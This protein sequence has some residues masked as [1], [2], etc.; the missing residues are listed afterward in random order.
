MTTPE[1]RKRQAPIR[2]IFT[3]RAL[4]SLKAGDRRISVFD[5]RA[6]GLGVCVQ[7][8]G[9]KSYFHL[10]SVQGRPVRKVLGKVGEIALEDA[11]HKAAEL[12][13][14]LGKWKFDEYETP[15]PLLVSDELRIAGLMRLYL[16]RRI[17][18]HSVRPDD[19]RKRILWMATRYFPSLQ[20]RLIGSITRMDLMELHGQIA[21]DSGP[22]IAN[23]VIELVRTLYSWAT[24]A[25]LWLGRNPA[26]KFEMLEENERERF[27]QPSEMPKFFQALGK[28]SPDF[29]D[30]IRLSLFTG[31][32]KHDI[33]SMSWDDVNIDDEQWIV[34]HPK[35]EMPYVVAL[36][37]ETIEILEAR[38]LRAIPG[39][40]W[41]FPSTSKD[42]HVLDMKT[43]WR[44]F[45][46][47]TGLRDLHPHDLRRSLG[48]W[49]AGLNASMP[50]IAKALGHRSIDATKVYSRVNLDPVRKSIQAAARAMIAAG[51]KKPKQL[52][53]GK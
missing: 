45:I 2:L 26:E 35:N 38:R 18:V 3:E 53:G 8:T 41:V 22:I 14:K 1:A 42:G 40:R 16:D 24:K 52:R 44:R 46:R 9:R 10:K 11:R 25:G 30:Y 19:A 32:R 13:S 23:R 20:K 17:A 49:Q 21:R 27:V 7:T 48:S 15:N 33:V 37:A 51:A 6:D 28:M 31:A 5:K 4:E 12:N 34:P 39:N 50:I 29:Q 36:T 43:A 47:I